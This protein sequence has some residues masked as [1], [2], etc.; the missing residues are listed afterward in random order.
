MKNTYIFFLMAGILLSACSK[1]LKIAPVEGITDYEFGIKDS[2]YVLKLDDLNENY[3]GFTEKEISHIFRNY[4]DTVDLS[5]YTNDPTIEGK[6]KQE[7]E[8]FYQEN[9]HQIA[10]SKGKKPSRDAKFLLTTLNLAHEEGLHPEDYDASELLVLQAKTYNKKKYINIFELIDLDL[11][12]TGAL[13]TYAWHL[14]NGRINPGDSDWRWAFDIP[15]DPVAARLSH[16]VQNKKL[17]KELDDMVPHHDQYESLK[18]AL[19]DLKE[20]KHEGGW[21]ILPDDLSLEE[22]DTSEFVYLL[23][24]RLIASEDHRNLWKKKLKN[25]VFD[26]KL[27]EALADFQRRHGLVDD[28]IL[29]KATIEMLNVPVEEKIRVVELNLE[30][31]RWMPKEMPQDYILINL[32]EYRLKIFEKDKE[33]FSMRIIIG[34]SYKHATPIFHDELEYLVLSPTWGV[35]R[36]IVRDEMMPM[37]KKD[38]GYLTRNGYQLYVQG[39]SAPVNPHSVDWSSDINIRVV[40]APG[41]TN[42]LGRVKFIM[43]NRF[44]IYL[45]DT[46]ADHLFEQNERDFSHGCVRLERPQ[47]LAEYLLQNDRKWD[48]ERIQEHMYKEHPSTV[49]LK[50]PLPVYIM[51]QTAFI[52]NNGRINF[53]KDIYEHDKKQTHLIAKERENY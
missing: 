5:N 46:P 8:I 9:N 48:K 20:F 17:K 50:E 21:P 52:D 44:N 32:P 11:K 16:A 53:R 29:G 2:L 40:Q 31:L 33:A 41:P 4:M 51:Y 49:W 25:P 23:R 7:L 47:K 14:E 6:L 19:T 1:K 18:K 34:K 43:P 38:P 15:E 35:P 42:A 27:K 28:G 30:R 37:I 13:L 12:L 10:W 45:H 39:G 22:G 36:K 3:F 24:E 26:S